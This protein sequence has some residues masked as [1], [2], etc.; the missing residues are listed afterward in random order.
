MRRTSTLPLAA[1][2]WMVAASPAVRAENHVVVTSD[3]DCPSGPAVTQALWAFRPDGEWPALRATLRATNDQVEVVLGEDPDNKREIAATGD[4]A[5]R[6]NQ[7]ALVIAIWSGELP[8]RVTG[9]PTLTVAAPMP[10]PAPVVK[11]DTAT[12]I[13]LQGFSSVVGGNAPGLQAEL[14]RFHR[15]RRWGV[16]AVAAYQGA[17][18]LRVDIGETQYQRAQLGA[19]LVL[20]WTGAR[21]FTSGELGILGA[22]TWAHGDGYSQDQSAYGANVGLSLDGRVGLALRRFRLW[23]A[24]QGC[25]WANKE[26]VR[27]DPLIVGAPTTSTLP[28][29]DARLGLGASVA[30][31]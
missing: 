21:L 10:A 29:W 23:A 14:G 13:G 8:S 15:G 18:S 20:R 30:F 31:E 5:D 6:A 3:G 25:R 27:V 24:L 17:R 11:P 9:A 7:V 12:E 4:C 1:F 26:I 28:A 19:F 2:V 22:L 16:R